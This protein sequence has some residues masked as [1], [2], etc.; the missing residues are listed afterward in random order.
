LLAHNELRKWPEWLQNI[1]DLQDPGCIRKLL[2]VASWRFAV[3]RRH[4]L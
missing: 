3:E 4:A 1:E 2:S